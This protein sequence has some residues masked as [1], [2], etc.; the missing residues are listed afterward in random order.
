MHKTAR[1]RFAFCWSDKRPCGRKPKIQSRKWMGIF[2][3]ALTFVFVG[4]T[5][6]AQQPKK[7]S[8]IGYLSSGDPASESARSEGVRLA[9]RKLG[10]MGGSGD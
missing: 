10:Y 8:R 7:I 2:A 4:A 1:S 6:T 5:A 9:L 3:I